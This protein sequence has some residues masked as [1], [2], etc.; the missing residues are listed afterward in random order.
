VPEDLKLSDMNTIE[1]LVQYIA[2]KVAASGSQAAAPT[3]T[4]AVA[5]PIAGKADDGIHRFTLAVT[6]ISAA[7]KATSDFKG[8]T[9]LISMDNA[10]FTAKIAERIKKHG[11]NVLT[12]GNSKNADCQVDMTD[13][14]AVEKAVTA[15]ASA[16][17]DIN[18]FIHL[19]PIDYALNRTHS[20]PQSIESSIKSF[21]II[22]KNLNAMLRK[23]GSIV[24]QLSFNS[25]VFPYGERRGEIYPV[26]A[27][28]AGML[29]TINK[30]FTDAVVKAVD[31]ST[32][33][34]KNSM[35]ETS[36]TFIMELLSG[37][38]RV[39]VGYRDGARY[40]MVLKDEPAAK[41]KSLVQNGSTLLVT[42]GAGGITYEILARLAKDFRDL[43]F[44]VFDRIDIESVKKE[45]L[46][47]SATEEF[48]IS[49][50]KDQMPGAKPLEIKNAAGLMMRAKKAVS[51]MEQ[52]KKLGA[53]VDYHSVD[54]N[55]ADSVS[56]ALKK[57]KK[58]DGVLHAA[59]MEESQ[60]IEKMTLD[61]FNR[62]FNVKVYGVLN[63]LAALSKIE[64]SFFAAFSSVAARFGNEGQINYSGGNEMLAKTLFRERAAHKNRIYKICDWTAWEG[65]GMATNETVHK[66]LKDRGM[67]FLP[68][69]H[70][71]QLFI[72]ELS[73]LKAVESLFTGMDTSFD[74]DGILP[75]ASSP[76]GNTVAPFLD[77][78]INK[79]SSKISFTR[80][81]DLKRDLFILDHTK[82]GIPLFLGATG[83][84]TMA[85]AAVELAGKGMALRELRDFQIPYSIKILKER[86]K[87]IIV[88]AEKDSKSAD[89]VKCRI[90]SQFKNPKGVVVGDPTLHYE[91]SYIFSGSQKQPVVAIPNRSKVEVDG[92]FQQII[93]HPERLFMDG[94][95]R[96][97]QGIHYF[98]GET[99]VSTMKH[100]P[101]RDFFKGDTSPEFIVDVVLID[102]MFQTGGIFEMLTTSDIILPSKIN[103]MIFHEAPRK[104][105]EYLCFTKKIASGTEANTFSLVLAD[106][107]GKVYMEIDRFDMVKVTRVP[108]ENRIDKMFR[109]TK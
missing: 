15:F 67:T 11:G 16:H 26:F 12:I 65:A 68:M 35:D 30:E 29:K 49:A 2:S 48:I 87:E 97:V 73:D 39:E 63:L 100:A 105:V 79:G 19:N 81:L 61:S 3:N 47:E 101:E 24:A 77:K 57:Y 46:A 20:S 36:D 41:E 78:V 44:I 99:L 108:L 74:K 88:E 83:M 1:K 8:K 38:T 80:T 25:V 42:G 93:Y 13:T 86:P 4:A 71:I 72:D 55:S 66:V 90:T 54:V 95:F 104:D 9:F 109:I 22:V 27:G 89:T 70:G 84:E 76:H 103:R 34:P 6:P 56:K 51:N 64:Y 50:L 53:A 58:I 91:G 28:V 107:S 62:V 7:K 21:F 18:S 33:K 40:G 94:V 43:K 85:E 69:D 52:L 23:K 75:G 92:D 60:I 82:D 31:F 106:H 10:G 5:A 14:P 17:S 102:A 98:D 96:T 59:G 45:F 37:D 32:D